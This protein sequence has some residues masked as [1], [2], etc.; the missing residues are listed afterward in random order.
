[1][2]Q[3]RGIELSPGI[4]MGNIYPYSRIASVP[5]QKKGLGLKLETDRFHSARDRISKHLLE[6]QVQAGKE[7]RTDEAA[8]FM[9]IAVLL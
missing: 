5:E 4:A 9:P 7:A 2:L 6:L 1:M 3:Y 8:I